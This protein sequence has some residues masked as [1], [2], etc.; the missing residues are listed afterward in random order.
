MT[1]SG[2][3]PR[4]IVLSVPGFIPVADLQITGPHAEVLIE[5]I[6]TEYSS[7][8]NLIAVA[9]RGPAFDEYIGLQNAIRAHRDVLFHDAVFANAGSGSDNHIGMYTRSGRDDS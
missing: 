3:V 2:L 9:H 1:D 4:E 6:R 7:G 5:G 8:R